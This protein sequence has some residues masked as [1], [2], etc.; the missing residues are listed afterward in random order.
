MRQS[1]TLTQRWNPAKSPGMK[2]P[3]CCILA[4]FLSLANFRAAEPADPPPG[5]PPLE[6]HRWV[7]IAYPKPAAW[8]KDVTMPGIVIENKGAEGMELTFDYYLPS[9]F[10]QERNGKSK[11][12][13]A[14]AQLYLNKEKP[15]TL[16]GR[17]GSMPYLGSGPQ[18]EYREYCT[19]HT[20]VIPWGRNALDDAWVVLRFKGHN[21]WVELPYGFSRNPDDPPVNVKE[22]RTNPVFPVAAKQL[23]REDLI[24]PWEYVTYQSDDAPK[25]RGILVHLSNPFDAA[26]E[27]ELWGFPGDVR[28]PLATL[29]LID[30]FGRENSG[31]CVA[32]SLERDSGR[33]QMFF[34]GRSPSDCRHW[35]TVRFAIGDKV[36]TFTIPSSLFDMC[37]GHAD[38]PEKAS[39][40]KLAEKWSPYP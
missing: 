40:L 26:G 8:R 10:D 25:N 2:T 32:L 11:P 9:Q 6:K 4:L 31:E 39:K 27:L 15:V 23:G 22:D 1:R 18:D 33:R 38:V 36:R 16:M 30:G 17:S 7:R 20:F 5:G 3:F 37:Q 21:F 19:T 13:K 35:G 14:T 12:E 34:Y 29:T 28:E 24:I